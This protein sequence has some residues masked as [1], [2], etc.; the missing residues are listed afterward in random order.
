MVWRHWLN[1]LMGIWFVIAPWSLG[2]AQYREATYSSVIVG[3]LLVIV[4]VWAASVQHEPGWRIWQDWVSS[5]FGFWFVI[6]PFLG[7]FEVGQYY[8]IVIPAIV[9]I[10]LSFWTLMLTPQ[11]ERGNA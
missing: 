2:V 1:A 6:H 11:S 10:A 8:A 4:S 3:T 9:T 7:H 5:L